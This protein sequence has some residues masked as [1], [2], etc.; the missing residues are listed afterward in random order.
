MNNRTRWAALAAALALGG[1]A[2]Q[3][4]A[5]PGANPA[6]FTRQSAQCD[7]L[8]RSGGGWAFA[9]GKPA[10]VGGAMA[11]YAIGE[12]IKVHRNYV[13]CMEMQGWVPVQGGHS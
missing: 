4:A 12:A 13:D 3:W 2:T 8:A 9:V 1:C 5:G 6:Y 7:V 11:G 10:F